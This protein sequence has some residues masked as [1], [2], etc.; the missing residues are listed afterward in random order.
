MCTGEEVQGEIE[1]LVESQ[2]RSAYGSDAHGMD[3]PVLGK[4]EDAIW[5]LQ[6]GIFAQNTLIRCSGS[7]GKPACKVARD[8]L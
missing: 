4:V 7:T 6:G 5:A 1:V 2:G 8:S 3:I